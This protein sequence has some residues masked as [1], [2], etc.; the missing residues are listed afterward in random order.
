MMSKML[1]D[2]F[3]T[4]LPHSLVGVNPRGRRFD[5]LQDS[6]QDSRLRIKGKATHSGRLINIRVYPG[7]KLK[8]SIHTFTSPFGKPIL[9]SHPG[10]GG[11]PNTL[12]RIDGTA[13]HATKDGTEFEYDWQNPD[14]KGEGSGYALFDAWI[15]D[16]E[17][18]NK[19]LDGRYLTFSVGFRT[20]SM[21]CSICNTNVLKEP[22][23][24]RPGQTYEVDGKNHYCFGITG[25]LDYNHIATVYFPA[26]SGA[27]L[28][29]AELEYQEPSLP[30]INNGVVQAVLEDSAGKKSRLCLSEEEID[31]YA[32]ENAVVQIAFDGKA[33]SQEGNMEEPIKESE[34]DEKI[35]QDEPE[36]DEKKPEESAS[37]SESKD[38]KDK[39]EK[40][41]DKDTPKDPEEEEEEEEEDVP[42]KDK[43]NSEESKEETEEEDEEDED[44][45]LAELDIIASVLESGADFEWN[46]M[47]MTKD[48]AENAIETEEE[49]E[50][51]AIST[52]KRKSLPD[53]IFCGPDRSFPVNDCA[54]YTAALRL[55][56]RYKGS[57]DKSKIR[58]CIEREGKKLD[59]SSKNGDG[60][61]QEKVKDQDEKEQKVEDAIEKKLKRAETEIHNLKSSLTKAYDEIDDLLSKVVDKDTDYR[62]CLADQILLS[63]AILGIR[64]FDSEDEYEQSVQ[65]LADRELNFLEQTIQDLRVELSQKVDLALPI[66]KEEVEPEKAIGNDEAEEPINQEGNK[67]SSKATAPRRKQVQQAKFKTF[68]ELGKS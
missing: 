35:E 65:E 58:A 1:F 52:K 2:N 49:K 22:C 50:D 43:S 30:V 38:L 44:V 42:E 46:A 3:G 60:Q 4:K 18:I 54:H 19:F 5:V 62:R 34:Q 56:G 41:E 14:I 53:S 27:V 16:N 66:N 59:C 15:S 25:G 48:E 36:K 55:L 67:S 6:Y 24:H 26:D 23:D 45:K 12:G 17:A 8:D 61:E 32:P 68:K 11:E 33:T 28:Q 64:K 10:L 57:G 31:Q 20:D 29:S 7:L 21:R 47:S 40:P 37:K 9:D 39:K 63:K 51:A 13:Y